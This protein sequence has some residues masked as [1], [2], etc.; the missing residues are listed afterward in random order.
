M[1]L[2]VKIFNGILLT[3]VSCSGERM[4]VLVV[5]AVREASEGE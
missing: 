3:K 5:I 4:I 2:K 1:D